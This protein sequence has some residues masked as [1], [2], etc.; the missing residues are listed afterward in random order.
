MSVLLERGTFRPDRHGARLAAARQAETAAP[1]VLGPI[2]PTV[3][4]GIGPAG[5]TFLGQKWVELAERRAVLDVSALALLRLA[6]TLLDDQE[7]TRR[8]LAK[9]GLMLYSGGG[10]KYLNPLASHLRKIEAELINVLDK[11]QV[12]DGPC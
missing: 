11:L 3:L 5:R 12:E 8:D 7:T 4:E 10:R 6:A 9:A 2:P 1:L